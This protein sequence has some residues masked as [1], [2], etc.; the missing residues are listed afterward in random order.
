MGRILLFGVLLLLVYLLNWLIRAYVVFPVKISD[1]AMEPNLAQGDR[2][3]FSLTPD[4]IHRNEVVYIRSARKGVELVCRVIALPGE[5]IEIK[6]QRVYI[7]SEKQIEKYPVILNQTSLPHEILVRDN[8]PLNTLEQDHYFCLF[9][10]RSFLNDSRSWGAF[11]K[12]DI[13]GVAH[14]KGLLGKEMPA[15]G[16]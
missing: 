14:S 11:S 16:L 5:S 9:D 7:N 3:F 12:Q 6:D 13:F 2:V 4:Q 15:Q 10:N 1:Q 8:Y